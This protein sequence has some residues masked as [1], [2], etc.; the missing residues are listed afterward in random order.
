MR[1]LLSFGIT[2]F[3][4]AGGLRTTGLHA[5]REYIHGCELAMQGAYSCSR[6]FCSLSLRSCSDSCLPCLERKSRDL[7]TTKSPTSVSSELE[8][9]A[10]SQKARTNLEVAN[11]ECT[12]AIV[13]DVGREELSHTASGQFATFHATG[14]QETAS[15][16]RIAL[17]FPPVDAL[18]T[19]A[20]LSTLI[21]SHPTCHL[22]L[23]LFLPL[24]LPQP[25]EPSPSI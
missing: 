3:M 17:Q 20:L 19:H 10:P 7:L 25:K 11:C 9:R 4:Y 12:Q 2:G 21:L 1:E 22:L 8:G 6:L 14:I 18:D 5:N 24:C 13:L 16:V 23:S 15:R